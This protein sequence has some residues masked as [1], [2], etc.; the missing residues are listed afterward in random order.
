[1]ETSKMAGYWNP[2]SDLNF[3][4]KIGVEYYM[5][6]RTQVFISYNMLQKEG[7][8]YL[9][10]LIKD[11]TFLSKVLVTVDPYALSFEHK[12]PTAEKLLSFIESNP[13]RVDKFLNVSKVR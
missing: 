13:T 3:N 5:E 8:K 6:K 9:S 7:L 2:K 10:T 1:V 4:L 12:D 11:P